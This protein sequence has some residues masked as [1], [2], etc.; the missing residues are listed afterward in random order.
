M[1]KGT[2]RKVGFLNSATSKELAAPVASFLHGL[3]QAGFAKKDIDVVYRF[4]KHKLG[5]LPGLA[6]KL[7]KANVEVLAATGGIVS[8][9]AAVAAVKAANKSIR[10]VYVCGYDLATSKMLAA[11]GNATGVIT[12]TTEQLP[13]RLRLARTLL[14]E[15]KEIALLVR[16]KTEVGISE[17][18]KFDPTK[19]ALPVLEADTDEELKKRFVEAKKNGQALLVSSDPFFTSRRKNIVKLAKDN[20]VSAI[21]AWREYVDAGG[22]MSFGPSLPNAYRQAGVY[23]GQVLDDPDY[24]PAALKPSHYEIAINV[25]TAE[26]LGINVPRELLA[27]ADHVQ[28]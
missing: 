21:Y 24:Q 14:G 13:E 5:D 27:S 1:A 28:D 3:N 18:D 2:K 6:D 7:V 22:L 20:K 19:R 16:P 4:A 23:V 15:K 8:A 11:S 9:K 12:A 17:R 10:I 26:A 25:K